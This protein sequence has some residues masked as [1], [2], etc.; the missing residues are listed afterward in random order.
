MAEAVARKHVSDI[1]EPSSAGLVPL[2][3]IA[4]LTQ[5]TL[6]ANGYPADHLFSKPLVREA[7]ED[8]DL[9][10]NLCGTPLSRYVE[11]LA[12]ETRA[13][14][15]QKIEHWKIQDPY[16]EDPATYQ[17]ILEEIESRV[18]LLGG[19]LRDQQRKTT[20]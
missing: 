3:H 8:A 10:I 9:I 17:R 5:H 14:I 20:V 19:R 4:L 15:E 6:L 2:G 16:G 18:L 1:I 7:L 11:D 12:H 13:K